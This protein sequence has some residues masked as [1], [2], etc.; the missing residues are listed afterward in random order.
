MQAVPHRGSDRE[1]NEQVLIY[2][3]LSALA[4]FVAALALLCLAEPSPAAVA[5]LV[6][7]VGIVPLI[8]GAITHFVPVLTR[9]G[10]AQRVLLLAPLLLQVAAGMAF[11]DFTGEAPAAIVPAA[12]GALLIA[13]VFAGWLVVRARRTLG[14]P[15]PGW[16]WYLAA[17]AFLCMAL[18]LVPAMSWWPEARQ[19]LRLLH[20][21]LNVLGFVGMSALGTLQVLLPTVLSGP[22]AAAARRL[23]DDLPVAAGGVLLIASGAAAWPAMA[24]LGALMLFAVVVKT[25][26]AWLR[27][28]GWQTLA[29]DGTAT[30]LAGALAAFLLLLVLGVAHAFTALD[31]RDAVPAFI[32][33]FLLPLVSGALTQLLPVWFFPGTRT[34]AQARMRAALRHG[35]EWRTLLFLLAGAL[36]ALG[37]TAAVWLAAAG[38]LSFAIALLYSLLANRETD[39]AG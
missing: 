27:R 9:T 21:H 3:G 30:P 18:I 25:A 22:D 14:R 10:S 23:R 38:L 15:H 5:H 29:G 13:I 8:F 32:V 6:F 31:G 37:V 2:L 17:I 24:L 36:L 11:F 1:W 12:I 33:G 34:P 4:T 7:A 39:Q 20:L 35:G 28:Y 19:E 16:R 26:L